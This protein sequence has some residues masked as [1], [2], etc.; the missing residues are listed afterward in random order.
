MPKHIQGI[1]HLVILV[2]DLD[3]AAETYRRLGFTL[4]PR[5]VHSAHMGSANHTVMLQDDYFELLAVTRP[6]PANET[7]RTRLAAGEGIWATALKTDDADG[8]A[9]EMRALGVPVGD[10]LA[11]SRPVERPDGGTVEAAFRIA[12]IT[13]PGTARDGLFACQHLT[14]AAVW[15]PELMA[16][17]NGALGLAA[18]DGV[19]EDPARA[20]AEIAPLFDATPSVAADGAARLDAGGVAVRIARDP[21]GAA[22]WPLRFVGLTLAVSDIAQTEAALGPVPFTRAGPGLRVAPDRAHGVALS[23]TPRA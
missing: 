16:H 7:W 1:D 19:A 10:A 4:S 21:A 17:A 9:E 14:R 8:M 22:G 5:G 20:A 11:F 15:R 18:I 13:E 12:P 2:A 3:A 6:T 23:F